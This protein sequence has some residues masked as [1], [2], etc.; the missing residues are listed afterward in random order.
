MKRI[1]SIFMTLVMLLTITPLSLAEGDPN[2]DGGGDGVG[3][4]TGN[5]APGSTTPRMT[6]THSVR[7][8]VRMTRIGTNRRQRSFTR[9]TA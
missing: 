3:R 8:M 2:L 1:I 6:T 4:A 5:T 9:C 7:D